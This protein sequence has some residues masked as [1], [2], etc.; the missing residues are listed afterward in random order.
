MH[1]VNYRNDVHVRCVRVSRKTRCE[2]YSEGIHNLISSADKKIIVSHPQPAW[3]ARGWLRLANDAFC[4][5]G[6]AVFQCVCVEY[7]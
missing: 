4:V 1:V 5:I 7:H 6:S 2:L 3:R